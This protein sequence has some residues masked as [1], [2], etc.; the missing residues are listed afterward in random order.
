MTYA[1]S[2]DLRE[3]VYKAYISRASDIGITSKEFNN[4]P[5]MDEILKLRSEMSEL[6]GFSNYAEYST[7]SKMVESPDAVVE[8]LSSLIELSIPQAKTELIDLE[9]FAGHFLMPWDL[10]SY[11][12]K[13]KQKTFSFKSSDLKP[14]FP[15]S[16]VF[17]LSLIHI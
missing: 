5:I 3:E 9:S 13:L 6:V 14:F 15:E 7:Q 12:E 4:R 11:S 17:D 1:D 8:F 2:R 16:S 10:M